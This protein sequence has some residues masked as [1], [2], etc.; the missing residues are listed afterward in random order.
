[1]INFQPTT[2]YKQD[3][4]ELI[5]ASSQRAAWGVNLD[6]ISSI[7]CDRSGANPVDCDL[8]LTING[9]I[10]KEGTTIEAGQ[11][12]GYVGNW[13]DT[14]NSGINGRTELTV[15][16][17]IRDDSKRGE[18]LGVRNHCPTMYLDESV[19]L[20]YKSKIQDLMNSFETW[21]G[22]S[23]NYPQEQMVS[24]G[25]RYTAIEETPEGKTTPVTG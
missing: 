10:I 6:H 23:S 1:M 19:E 20:L 4:W 15:F 25:C 9:E 24:P 22:D 8:P 7:D 14:T 13:Q 2:S 5:I 3:D 17:Y 11:V 21:S 16:E 18:N 12:L